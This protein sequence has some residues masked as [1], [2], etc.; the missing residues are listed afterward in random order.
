MLCSYLYYNAKNK[1]QKEAVVFT[2]SEK[3]Q[4]T[5]GINSIFTTWSSCS[6]GHRVELMV[7]KLADTLGERELE[8]ALLGS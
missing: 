3:T 8:P 4:F 5:R 2:G 6:K 7:I 1:P